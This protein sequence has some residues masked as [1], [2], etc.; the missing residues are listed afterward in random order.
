MSALSDVVGLALI[1]LYST[2]SG[3]VKGGEK[4]EEKSKRKRGKEMYQYHFGPI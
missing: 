4:R 2:K 1:S 3:K